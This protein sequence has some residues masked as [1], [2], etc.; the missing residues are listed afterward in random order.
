[1]LRDV[2][3]GFPMGST[4][5]TSNRVFQAV[6][7]NLPG[8]LNPQRW[9]ALNPQQRAPAEHAFR[10]T[11]NSPSPLKKLQ[12]KRNGRP[13]VSTPHAS[14]PGDGTY[15]RVRTVSGKSQC[16]VY[17]AM[18]YVPCGGFPSSKPAQLSAH[19]HPILPVSVAT[20]G[21]CGWLPTSSRS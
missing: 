15:P 6:Q 9:R 13:F 12:L 17:T 18:P 21:N 8:P 7:D 3:Q 2:R 10:S 20:G 11:V 4:R 19:L 1:M 5:P 14:L 16:A